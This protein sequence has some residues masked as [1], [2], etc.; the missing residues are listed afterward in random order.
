MLIFETYADVGKT[1]G[2]LEAEI[3]A[4]APRPGTEHWDKEFVDSFRAMEKLKD[5]DKQLM[6][7]MAERRNSNE[8]VGMVGKRGT[9]GRD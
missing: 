4:H 1:M 5:T 9:A 6:D 2:E 8:R 7:M 3:E